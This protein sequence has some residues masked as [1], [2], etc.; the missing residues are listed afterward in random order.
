MEVWPK[1]LFNKLKLAW[2]LVSNSFYNLGLVIHLLFS[3]N[4]EKTTFFDLLMALAKHFEARG[5]QK[6]IKGGQVVEQEI[7]IKI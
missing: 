6:K 2:V 7:Q 5:L 1:P 3:K 4:D